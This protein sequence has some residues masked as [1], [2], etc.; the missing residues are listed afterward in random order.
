MSPA[1]TVPA[2]A[3]GEW[4]SYESRS[5]ACA[6]VAADVVA[7]ALLP[8]SLGL[9]GSERDVANSEGKIEDMKEAA[10]PALTSEFAHVQLV[11]DSFGERLAAG[12]RGGGRDVGAGTSD[13]EDPTTA[14]A[15]QSPRLDD[16]ALDQ[17]LTP[18]KDWLRENCEN[19]PEA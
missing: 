11:I 17:A 19:Q 2:T 15:R 16:D 1:S 4:G 3:E 7:I 12:E 18:V 13:A 6:A 5:D 9:G 8:V 14:D 10:P